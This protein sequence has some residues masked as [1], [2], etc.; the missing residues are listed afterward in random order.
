MIG[1]TIQWL[2]DSRERLRKLPHAAR[3]DIGYQLS[4]IQAARP[5]TDWKPMPLVGPGVVEIRVHAEN[6]YRVFYLA[7]FY[8]SLNYLRY[9]SG[10]KTLK[11]Y[12][13]DL[14]DVSDLRSYL[15]HYCHPVSSLWNL[16]IYFDVQD[17]NLIVV[18]TSV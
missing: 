12:L 4:L 8:F 1:K 11:E 5:A 7:M 9:C 16:P 3:R 15:V 13:A 18:V 17:L 10:L 14:D 6:E 2:G